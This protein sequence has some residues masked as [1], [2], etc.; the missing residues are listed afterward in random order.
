MSDDDR[1]PTAVWVD[2]Q[3]RKFQ[4]EGKSCYV[5]NK[6]AYATGTVILKIN[7]LGSGCFLL[8]QQRNL[9]GELGWMR[10]MKG[11]VV[12]EITVDDYIRRAIDRDPDLWAIEIEDKEGINPFEGKIF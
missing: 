8:Q 4:A 1:I 5:M 2:A 12:S 3:L 7:L 10:L 11:E 9:D 6:G